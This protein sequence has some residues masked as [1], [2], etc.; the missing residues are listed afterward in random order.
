MS[1]LS[2]IV[3]TNFLYKQGWT[4]K[5]D[6]YDN[7][8]VGLQTVLI[9][10]NMEMIVRWNDF[11][12]LLEINC[13][14]LEKRLLKRY[15]FF[16]SDYFKYVTPLFSQCPKTNSINS[17]SPAPTPSVYDALL[18]SDDEYLLGDDLILL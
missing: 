7:A 1:M 12:L 15:I 14:I 3:F 5:K 16:Q 17:P 9:K 10:D 8:M 18:L 4:V 11:P 6:G 2:Q 13:T